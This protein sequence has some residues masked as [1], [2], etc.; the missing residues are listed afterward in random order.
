MAKLAFT[1]ELAREC[2]EIVARYPEP[3]AALLPVLLLAQREFGSCSDEVAEFV[4]QLLG[5]TPAEV[6]G[7]STFYPRL[8]HG[9]PARHHVL[10]CGGLSCRLMGCPEVLKVLQEGL[11]IE[12][13]EVSADG[14]YALD[15]VECLGSCAT[16][17]VMEIDGDLH[18]SLTRRLIEQILQRMGR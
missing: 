3:R 18:P 2:E 10:V 17:P 16:A 4:G 8:R 15:R 1:P 9:R 11:G 14:L 12:P 6:K 13:G 5:V 7:V